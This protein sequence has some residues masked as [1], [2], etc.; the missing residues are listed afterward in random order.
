LFYFYKKSL[1]FFQDYHVLNAGGQCDVCNV[2]INCYWIFLHHRAAWAEGKDPFLFSASL[3][4][5]M[6][7][8][9]LNEIDCTGF[10]KSVTDCKFNTESQGCNHEEDAAVRCNVPAM[11]FQN[12]V[13]GRVRVGRCLHP[14][15]SSALPRCAVQGVGV[16]IVLPKPCLSNLDFNISIVLDRRANK[17]DAPF[18]YGV[19]SSSQYVTGVVNE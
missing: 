11:G 19:L 8:I 15:A 9:H 5:G 18:L 2:L 13:R 6:G 7:P 4:Q 3:P 16:G 1:D 17:D 12:Q 14:G 10:E